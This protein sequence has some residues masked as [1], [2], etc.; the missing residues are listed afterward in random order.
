[1]EVHVLGGMKQAGQGWA[2]VTMLETPRAAPVSCWVE[3][4]VTG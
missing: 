4:A 2:L 1:M 3:A